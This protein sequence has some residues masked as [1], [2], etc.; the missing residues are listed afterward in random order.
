M[1]WKIK[2]NSPVVLII[3]G[4]C[5]LSYLLNSFIVEVNDQI[6][7]IPIFGWKEIPR[8]FSYIFAHGSGDHIVGN[9]SLF[10]IVAPILEEKYGP[11]R[12][13]L[14]IIATSL[15]TAILHILF[16]NSALI[17][18]SG[19][20]FM[21]IIMVSFTNVKQGEIP[22]TLILVM[23]LFLGKEVASSFS[24]DN[25][26]QFAHIIGGILG[27]AFGFIIQPKTKSVDPDKN[28][29]GL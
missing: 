24:E 22:I 21:S 12:F 8:M 6:S 15:I 13:I 1:N 27:T 4:L 5:V 7:L 26:S 16:F 25:I 19:I 10:L 20:V 3:C 28:S 29:I 14:M 18:L 9:L 2:F 11:K 23:I 17:G